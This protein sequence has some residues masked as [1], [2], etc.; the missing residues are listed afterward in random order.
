MAL[1]GVVLLATGKPRKRSAG[2]IVRFSPLVLLILLCGCGSGSGG[3]STNM[4]GTPAGT[5][6]LMVKATSGTVSQSLPLTLTV[7]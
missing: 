4:N 3:T 5:Y 6:A 7:Q 2:R 1:M